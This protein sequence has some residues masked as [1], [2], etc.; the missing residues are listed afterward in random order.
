[1]PGL[2]PVVLRSSWPRMLAVAATPAL[3]GTV[4]LFVPL[5]TVR[6]DPQREKITPGLVLILVVIAAALS[7][8][9]LYVQHLNRVELYAGTLVVRSGWGTHQI[10]AAEIEAVTLERV[11]GSRM[12][13]I[14]TKTG[15]ARRAGVAGRTEG[16][17]RQ[18][19]DRDLRLIGDWW[20]ANRGPDWRQDQRTQHSS[21]V[22]AIADFDW[23][24]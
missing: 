2:G 8:F 6:H 19:F 9:T 7:G 3:C 20:L 23:R 21:A 24:P 22:A 16:L 15:A 11:L 14:W 12:V 17:F 18:N 10:P 4:G 1:M 5:F 13:T